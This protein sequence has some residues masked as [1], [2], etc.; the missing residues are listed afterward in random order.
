MKGTSQAMMFTVIVVLLSTGSSARAQHSEASKI[1]IGAQFSSF[2]MPQPEIS[3]GAVSPGELQSEP[4]FG[5]RF[6]YNLTNYLALEAEGNFFPHRNFASSPTGGRVVQGQFGVKAGKRFNRFGIFAK[7]RPGFVSFS[8]VLTEVGRQTVEFEGQQFSFPIIEPRRKTYFST[9]VGAVLEFYPSRRILARF[10]AGDTIIRY[11]RQPDFG[12]FALSPTSAAART[13]HNFQ[14]SAGIGLRLLTSSDDDNEAQASNAKVPRIEIGAQFSSLSLSIIERS[15]PGA[16]GSTFEFRDTQ[17]EAGFG[18]RFTYNLT[19]HF[20]LEAEGNFFPHDRRQFIS[21][22]SGGRILQ[23]Q[24]GA[25]VGKRFESFGIFAKARPG[26]VSFSRTVRLDG[27]DTED[28]DGI[29]ISFP[30]ISLERR[31][32]FSLDLGGVLEFYPSRRIVTRLDAGDTLIR[33][34]STTLPA[35]GVFGMGETFQVPAETR[36]NF[37]FSAGIGF[38]F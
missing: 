15:A 37:Q 26:V 35:P 6:T 27:F 7:A 8:D 22:R 4:G 9:D 24:F 17:T 23:G 3:R 18:G 33:Y 25:K 11:G 20:A 16:V 13:R 36:H 31:N 1:E 2:N 34:S 12:T 19:E 5:G 14:F 29:Q 38:R 21:G 32:Y 28:F 10:D 30:R